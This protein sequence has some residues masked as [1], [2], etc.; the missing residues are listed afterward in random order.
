MDTA[1]GLIG[2]TNQSGVTAVTPPG[3]NRLLCDFSHMPT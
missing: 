3:E 1:L 2:R